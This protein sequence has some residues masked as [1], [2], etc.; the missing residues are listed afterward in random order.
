MRLL[1]R[2]L[3]WNEDSVRVATATHLDPANPLA[4]AAGLR[5]LHLCEYGAQAMALHGGLLA[6]RDG[7]SAAPGMLV[8]LRD[9]ELGVGDLRDLVGEL[10]VTAER[11]QAGEGA[12][13][14]RFVVTH[15]GNVIASG[16]TTVALRA[17]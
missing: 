10:V 9:V 14:Y 13:Q 6:R 11:L 2:V 3:D 4:T 8:L 12:W 15:A 1:E 7:R 17:A 16:R 5:A